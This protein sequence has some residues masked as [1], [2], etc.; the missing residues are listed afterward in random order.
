M[1]RIIDLGKLRFHFA[2]DWNPATVYEP[3]DV[4]KYGGNVYVYSYA[5][6]TSGNL[7]TDQAFW[8]LMLEGFKFQGAFDL[9]HQYRVGDGIAYGGR[10]YV[11]L[12]D[13][14]G[15]T[16]PNP[17]YW[18]QFVDGIQYEGEFSLTASYQRNDVV[19][20]GASIFIAKQDTTG[21]L[22]TV[23]AYWD[24]FI[25]GISP[26]GVYNAERAYVPN[27]IVAY[28]P[29][30]YR[31]KKETTG[32]IPSV[33]E[34]WE[35]LIGGSA[36][37]G[38]FDPATTYYLNDL[39]N[40]GGNLYRALTTTVTTLP[41]DVTK[42][43]LVSEGFS[44]QGVWSSSRKYLIGQTATYGGSLFRAIQDNQNANPATDSL[45]WSKLVSGY[46]YRGDWA[47]STA[48]ASD[49]VITYGGNSYISLVPHASTDFLTDLASDRWH[50]FNSGIRWRGLWSVS[51]QYLKDDIVKSG[52][53]TFIA[54]HD[55]LGGVE[56][57]LGNVDFE[58]LVAGIEGAL[59][60]SGDTM[61]GP[62]FLSRYP[63]E[64]MEAVPRKYV[65]SVHEVTFEPTGFSRG[66]PETMGVVEFSHDGVNVYVMDQYSNVTIRNDSKFA[67]GTAWERPA[68]AKTVMICPVAGQTSF[69]V[70]QS[71]RRYIFTDPQISHYDSL[72]GTNYYFFD[73]GTLYHYTSITGDY[74][75]KQA[76]VCLTYGSEDTGQ[77]LVFADERHGITMDGATHYY[78]HSTS[79]TRYRSGLGLAGI[80]AGGTQYV[81][82]LAGII[83]DE[84]IIHNIP[85]QAAGNIFVYLDGNRW[86]G[87]QL[88]DFSFSYKIGGVAQYNKKIA[89]D[90]YQ[91]ADI[92]EGYFAVMYFSA[93][94]CSIHRTMKILG[95]NV[96]SSLS[97]AR[98]SAQS[99]PRDT[100]LIGLPASEFLYTGAVIINR[101]GE[102]QTLD[103]GATYVD[104]RLVNISAGTNTSSA[105]QGV[106]SDIYFSKAK[107]RMTVTNVQEA[108]ELLRVQTPFRSFIDMSF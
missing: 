5:L 57:N 7:P 21:N 25:E 22:P 70:W 81:K 65:D 1:T 11:C 2:G 27:E 14:T 103:N 102:I 19:V 15:Q 44:Y 48:Y 42:W 90:T 54:L 26:S 62:L 36:F 106:A 87:S 37:R 98:E 45:N 71:G 56:P 17:V 9:E 108:I 105:T 61:G 49:D 59:A 16:P 74:I 86:R 30:L 13:C 47:T 89:P 85:E 99:E 84:D 10:I 80:S 55:T 38:T 34:Y 95:Q 100:S 12:L 31:A 88:P 104:L 91:L 18:S 39:S 40:Y 51:T 101:A 29:N 24:R 41:T 93:T 28:G 53:S 32:N 43:E 69:T 97:K 58:I 92:P 83:Y 35:V 46:R 64:D 78:L 50:R 63:V 107:S 8:A 6:K 4:V 68:T 76:F 66:Q 75:Q 60:K 3:N 20:Y 96:F 52:L 77:V 33:E 23:A 79:G 73:Q 82:T 67:T 72:S 94:N